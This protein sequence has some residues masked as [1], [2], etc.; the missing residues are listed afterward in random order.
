MIL[1]SPEHREDSKWIFVQLSQ[2]LTRNKTAFV[3]IADKI[4]NLISKNK[5]HIGNKRHWL[6]QWQIM[7]MNDLI[8]HLINTERQLY[9]NTRTSWEGIRYLGPLDT[10]QRRAEN[11]RQC[12]VILSL[13]CWTLSLCRR[14]NE[15]SLLNWG[16]F[17]S[18]E[19]NIN[20]RHW[21][22]DHLSKKTNKPFCWIQLLWA[23]ALFSSFKKSA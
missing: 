8:N 17:T 3:K 4:F 13:S 10:S 7:W 20:E 18:S 11:R 9:K 6:W 19:P 16:L 22:Q 1:S 12:Q 2:L 5:E 15:A 21:S 23:N 14:G